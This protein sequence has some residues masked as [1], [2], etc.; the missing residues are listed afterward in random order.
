MDNSTT[1]VDMARKIGLLALIGFGVIFLSGPIFAVLSVVLSILLVV[2]VFAGIGFLV[3]F[4][5]RLATAGSDVALDNVRDGFRAIGRGIAWCGRG[6]WTVVKYPAQAVGVVCRG[7][8]RL[9]GFTLRL[10]FGTVK[11][12][13]QLAVVAALGAALGAGVSLLGVGAEQELAVALPVNALAGAA[14]AV[15][16]GTG[17]TIFGGRASKPD[18][19][20][21]V[22][23]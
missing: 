15:V 3:W 21:V 19:R 4:P 16:V 17:L 7:A 23:A 2:M 22:A 6:I 20:S 12:A 13:S 1:S 11:A 18:T 8:G 9:V 5:I 14:I 10:A